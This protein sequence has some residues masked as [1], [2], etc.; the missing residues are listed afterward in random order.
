MTETSV[1][2]LTIMTLSRDREMERW[3]SGYFL[4]VC[5]I[6]VEWSIP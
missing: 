6:D 4:L 2:A 5:G 1:L 3:V